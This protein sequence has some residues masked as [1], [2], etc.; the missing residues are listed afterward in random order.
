MN[1]EKRLWLTTISAGSIAS[2]KMDAERE[3][4]RR[5]KRKQQKASRK[6]NRGK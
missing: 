3:Q 5:K 4:T 6:R 1:H 2:M